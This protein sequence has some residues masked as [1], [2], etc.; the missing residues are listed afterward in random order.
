MPKIDLSKYGIKGVTEILYN[1][2]KAHYSMTTM[3][4]QPYD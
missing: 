4:I 2:T 1:P 3:I